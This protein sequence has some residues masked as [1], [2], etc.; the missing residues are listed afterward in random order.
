MTRIK[1]RSK[2]TRR[3]MAYIKYREHIDSRDFDR[4]LSIALTWAM[5]DNS[6]QNR[7]IW[8]LYADDAFKLLKA[9]G[10]GGAA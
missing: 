6:S 5:T 9:Q 7:L 1:T 2:F 10:E 3:V 4:A 8:N